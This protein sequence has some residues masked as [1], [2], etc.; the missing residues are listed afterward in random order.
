MS[1]Q[2]LKEVRIFSPATVANVACGFD[3]LGFCIDAPGDEIVAR[4]SPTPGLRI[5]KIT[6]DDGR[7]P[8][9]SKKNTA[10]VSETFSGVWTVDAWDM[11]TDSGS[12]T[13]GSTHSARACRPN[14]WAK[15]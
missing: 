7:L 4:F 3:V 9:D 11:T 12:N 13:N 15:I 14:S 1:A 10:G 8:L 6:G 2:P 5:T